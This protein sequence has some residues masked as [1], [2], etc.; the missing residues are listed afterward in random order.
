MNTPNNPSNPGK[1]TAED[2]KA[3]AGQAS[4]EV[5]ARAE[6]ASQE[7]KAKTREQIEE[8]ESRAAETMDKMADATH[9]AADEL[10]QRNETTLSHY[11][12]DI[13]DGI[14]NLSNSL[15][16]KNTDELIRD[17][18]RLARENTGLFLLGSVAVGFGISRIAKANRST[19]DSESH[20][21]DY[22]GQQRS[23]T[24][25]TASS[26]AASSQTQSSAESTPSSHAST[27]YLPEDR[28]SMQDPTKP[29]ESRR[30]SPTNNPGSSAGS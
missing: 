15:Q 17:A 9:A 11:V 27:S 19:G 23:S 10:A 12:A 24:Y 7:A 13:A 14:S 3:K 2:V 20:W 5:K 18:S 8:Q 16:H 29:P 25:D 22:Y 4:S 26:P 6:Q 21:E 28:P 1:Q 30:S